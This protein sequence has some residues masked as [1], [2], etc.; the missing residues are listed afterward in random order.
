MIDN[1]CK[2]IKRR[3]L[4]DNNV[5]TDEKFCFIATG[6]WADGHYIAYS[7]LD[8]NGDIISEEEGAYYQIIYG[9]ELVMVR[10]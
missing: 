2:P 1:E 4:K 6:E 7:R 8:S 3:I 10:V 5:K 9:R